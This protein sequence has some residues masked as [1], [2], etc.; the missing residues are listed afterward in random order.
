MNKVFIDKPTDENTIERNHRAFT[1]KIEMKVDEKLKNY[2][3]FG[4]TG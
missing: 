1:I 4:R 3:E 2:L